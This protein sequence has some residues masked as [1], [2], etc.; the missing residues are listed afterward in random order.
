[1]NKNISYEYHVD[2]FLDKMKEEQHKKGIISKKIIDDFIYY[3]FTEYLFSYRNNDEKNIE[4]NDWGIFNS[5]NDE[6]F[7]SCNVKELL[8][9]KYNKMKDEDL[10]LNI[11]SHMLN[12]ISFIYSHEDKDINFLNM[13]KNVIDKIEDMEN[14]E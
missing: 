5:S 1:M 12:D 8:K 4:L 10:K 3:L 13:I 11:L 7:L 9:N 6:D 2:K 14:N